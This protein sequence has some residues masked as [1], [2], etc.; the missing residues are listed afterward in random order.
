MAKGDKKYSLIKIIV[1]FLLLS[2]LI[3]LWGCNR[4]GLTEIKTPPQGPSQVEDINSSL[5][6]IKNPID[7]PQADTDDSD[8]K[9]KDIEPDEDGGSSDISQDEEAPEADLPPSNEDN[10]ENR[11]N[12]EME[13][14]QQGKKLIV[15][16]PGHQRKGD[17]EK[18]PIGPGA[19]EMKAKVSSGTKGAATGKYE[20]ELNLEIA[21][22]LQCELEERGYDVIMVRTTH[23]VS[24]S[25]I[26]RTVIAN[27]ANADA[28]L[29]IHANGDAD[30]KMNGMLTVCPTPKSPYIEEDLYKKCKTL[31]GLILDN[32]V[33]Q[34][35]AKRLNVWETDT[36][37]GINWSR[38]PVT[39]IEMGF[40]TNPDEDK[41]MSEPEYQKKIVLG[42]A[43]GVDKYFCP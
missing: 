10:P 5:V 37:T 41:L 15:I 28:F 31:S 27:D 1:S 8:K 35:G 42:I 14:P 22:K 23:D 30:G 16:D 18:E 34:T 21:F 29:R 2:S 6:D 43:N 19:S 40:M 3:V 38:V 25:N 20:Y 36:M 24:I 17:S 12:P 32:M 11:G 26:E 13:E 33:E 7:D 4:A 39:L 9:I